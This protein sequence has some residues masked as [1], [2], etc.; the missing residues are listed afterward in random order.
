[1]SALISEM[2]ELAKAD[3]LNA[4]FIK[5]IV[6]V[7][8]ILQGVLLEMEAAFYENGIKLDTA[9]AENIMVKGDGESIKNCFISL[10]K[11]PSNIL[12]PTGISALNCIMK[13]G[14]RYSA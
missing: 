2:L 14:K 9:I 4:S 7:S 11:T 8:D 5:T 12:P 13:K 10:P 1:M 3:N 6:N